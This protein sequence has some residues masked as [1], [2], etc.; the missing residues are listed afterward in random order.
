MVLLVTAQPLAD[1]I[2]GAAA[3]AGGGVQAVLERMDHEIVA[4]GEFGVG[5]ADHGVVR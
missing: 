1:G 4:Q 2:A 5:G 3:V